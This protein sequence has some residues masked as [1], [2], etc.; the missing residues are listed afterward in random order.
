V[1]NKITKQLLKT[2]NKCILRELLCFRS[3]KISIIF[4][5]FE[6]IQSQEY[7]TR[8]FLEETKIVQNIQDKMICVWSIMIDSNRAHQSI[9]I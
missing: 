8:M 1:L 6:N 5:V 7:P 2:L 3:K 4:A 9:A